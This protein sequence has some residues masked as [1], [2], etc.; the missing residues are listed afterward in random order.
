MLAMSGGA[1]SG[2][3][4]DPNHLANRGGEASIIAGRKKGQRPG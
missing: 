4:R 1:M 2:W 3:P